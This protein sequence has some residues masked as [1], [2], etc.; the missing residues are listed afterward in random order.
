MD[1][2][3]AIGLVASAA[4][5]GD[6]TITVVRSLLHYVSEV[7]EAPA[8]SVELQNELATMSGMLLNL[9]ITLE[10]CPDNIADTRLSSLNV[11][12]T[13]VE[14]TLKEILDKLEGYVKPGQTKGLNRLKWPFK[15]Q[16]ISTYVE[17]L[18]RYNGTLLSAMNVQQLSKPSLIFD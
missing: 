2:I 7:K 12:F 1:P 18:Q 4:Q 10:T 16:E 3:T 5:L 11:T 13:K 9:K 6:Y 15:S 17:R 14:D 8:R